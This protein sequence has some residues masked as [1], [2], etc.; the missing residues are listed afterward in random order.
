MIQRSKIFDLFKNISTLIHSDSFKNQHTMS[1][2]NFT[3]KRKLPFYEIIICI[4]SIPKK[5]LTC[6]LDKYFEATIH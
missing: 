1:K 4:L 5:T 2:T 3:G 6:E